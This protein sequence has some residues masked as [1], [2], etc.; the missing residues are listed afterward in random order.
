[1]R[2]KNGLIESEKSG[3]AHRPSELEDDRFSGVLSLISVAEV[4][5]GPL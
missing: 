5:Q 4:M 3:S 1:M 2:Y